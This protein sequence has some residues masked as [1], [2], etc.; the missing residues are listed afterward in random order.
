LNKAFEV[1]KEEWLEEIESIRR[2]YYE[3]YSDNVPT[4]LKEQL[5][6]L[7]QRFS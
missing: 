1:N 2:Y 5:S 4:V 3:I 6:L 7:I